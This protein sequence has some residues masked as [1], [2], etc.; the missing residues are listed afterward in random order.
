MIDFEKLRNDL[1]DYYGTAIFNGLP[2]AMV[3]VNQVEQASNEE[4]IVIAKKLKIN[5]ERYF[6]K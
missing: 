6:R 2:M 5:M 1:K 3:N 4:L